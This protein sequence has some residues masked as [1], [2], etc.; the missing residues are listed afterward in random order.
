[1]QTEAI[2]SHFIGLTLE[3]PSIQGYFGITE[4]T[5]TNILQ[6]KS[7]VMRHAE[8]PHITLLY[9]PRELPSDYLSRLGKY[10]KSLSDFGELTH[11]YIGS[12]V[13]RDQ[14]KMYLYLGYRPCSRI[15]EI[16]WDL[17]SLER[18]DEVTDNALAFVPHITLADIDLTQAKVSRESIEK[19]ISAQ[20]SDMDTLSPISLDLYRVSSLFSPEMQERVEAEA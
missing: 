18:F 16:R 8:T 15:A 9:L 20:L 12:F 19:S 17:L 1:M 5:L 2:T 13:S 3:S 10:Q 7:F 14:S 11:P 6:K 4:H